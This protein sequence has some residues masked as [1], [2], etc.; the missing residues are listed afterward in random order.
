MPA[1]SYAVS[2]AGG[3]WFAEGTLPSGRAVRFECVGATTREAADAI[4]ALKWA[5]R[6]Q[7]SAASKS[8][9]AKVGDSSS[10]ASSSPAA[11]ARNAT[12]RGKLLSVGD[13]K[14]I[15]DDDDQADDDGDDDDDDAGDAGDGATVHP[16]LDDAKK[17]D[18]D[19]DEEKGED[20]DEAAELL[21]DVLGNGL[22]DGVIV[23]GIAKVMKHRKPPHRPGEPHELFV[24]YSREGC[25]YR[26]RKLVGKDSKL[27]PNGKLAIGL[28]GTIAMM[29]WNAEP[30]EEQPAAA[31]APAAAPAEPRGNLN[32]E[33]ADAG[34]G[35]F[36]AKAPA[37][38][39][40]SS[41]AP[42]PSHLSLVRAGVNGEP[43]KPPDDGPPWGSFG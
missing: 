19:D 9:W 42:R 29:L 21:A 16:S 13:A 22:Y 12:I 35:S 1:N 15:D 6:L 4:A 25:C 40:A 36:K 20:D 37:A 30:I 24:R 28:V 31:A 41:P 11:A 7:Q 33:A 2:E 32:G 43:P 18:D 23:G 39:A 14:P 8:R 34:K 27:G 38:A 3:K 5:Q 17:A 26:M 10:G